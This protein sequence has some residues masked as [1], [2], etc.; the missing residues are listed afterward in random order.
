[1]PLRTSNS[2]NIRLVDR[3]LVRAGRD[4]YRNC[5]RVDDLDLIALAN[6]FHLLGV[7]HD[8]IHRVALRSF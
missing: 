4:G 8:H 3:L 1:M 6:V 2:E 5:F 7:L